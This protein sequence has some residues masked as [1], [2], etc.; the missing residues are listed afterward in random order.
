[1]DNNIKIK[2][3]NHSTHFAYLECHHTLVAGYS[4]YWDCD[5]DN[6]SFRVD[7]IYVQN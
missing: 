6:S 2:F 1:M 7:A 3:T 4:E 5:S